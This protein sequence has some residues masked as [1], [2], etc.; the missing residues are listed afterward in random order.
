M[1]QF[2]AFIESH[3]RLTEGVIRC[4]VQ[5]H[6]EADAPQVTRATIE[7]ANGARRTIRVTVEEEGRTWIASVSKD[8][9]RMFDPPLGLLGGVVDRAYLGQLFLHGGGLLALPSLFLI[10]D[11]DFLN[12]LF[13]PPTPLEVEPRTDSSPSLWSHR[14]RMGDYSLSL[15]AHGLPVTGSSKQWDPENPRV[16]DPW[17]IH[18][19]WYDYSDVLP[20]KPQ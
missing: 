7:V 16:G 11:L 6:H 14:G 2:A 13:V 19:A 17:F 5:S 15:G 1:G 9:L 10:E 4:M 3:R 8:E 12:K 20:L 18:E